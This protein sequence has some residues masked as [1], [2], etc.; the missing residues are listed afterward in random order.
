MSIRLIVTRG[1]G[2]GTFNGDIANIVTRGYTIGT[3]ADIISTGPPRAGATGWNKKW[4]KT[5][6]PEKDEYQ[7]ELEVKAKKAKK[8]E[9]VKAITVIKAAEYLPPEMEPI[10]KIIH[11][12][13]AK[14]ALAI[15]LMAN[16]KA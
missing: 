9:V 16:Q 6:G 2:N 8:K 12:K 5:Y 13:L 11:V 10:K 14:Q 7:R 1:F 15:H 4:A 3:A